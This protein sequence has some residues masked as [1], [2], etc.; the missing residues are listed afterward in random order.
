MKKNLGPK[1]SSRDLLE[2]ILPKRNKILLLTVIISAF[3]FTQMGEKF[4]PRFWMGEKFH[5]R[6]WI[7]AKFHP[8][9]IERQKFTKDFDEWNIISKFSLIIQI[10]ILKSCFKIFLY[11]KVFFQFL[12]GACGE[13]FFFEHHN[14]WFSTTYSSWY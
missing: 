6:F 1:I 10:N 14:R 3:F 5:P 11:C 2:F 12:S 7:D 4:H 9:F 8:I 13:L